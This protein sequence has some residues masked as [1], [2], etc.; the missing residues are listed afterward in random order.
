MQNGVE[1]G[2]RN[3]ACDKVPFSEEDLDRVLTTYSVD[4]AN[5]AYQNGTIDI[6]L[7]RDGFERV[8]E[9]MNIIANEKFGVLPPRT[10]TQAIL[11]KAGLVKP[12]HKVYFSELGDRFWEI[13]FLEQYE[14]QTWDTQSPSQTDASYFASYTATAMHHFLL[15]PYSHI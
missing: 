7:V 12:R 5:L 3:Y 6:E 14:K 9:W 8:E 13:Q 10:M 11:E 4:I 15:A 2:L 1:E